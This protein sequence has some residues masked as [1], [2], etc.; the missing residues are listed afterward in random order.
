MDKNISF[1]KLFF[2]FI[3]GTQLRVN[4]LLAC[5]NYVA[6]FYVC[7]FVINYFGPFDILSIYYKIFTC[8]LTIWVFFKV[9]IAE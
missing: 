2:F 8:G 4:K 9:F 7:D 1:L 5:S 6:H 3:A